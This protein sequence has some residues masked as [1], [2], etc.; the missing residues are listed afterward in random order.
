MTKMCAFTVTNVIQNSN[1]HLT[2]NIFVQINVDIS[3]ISPF[4]IF[5]T[6]ICLIFEYTIL[7]NTHI[8][9]QTTHIDFTYVHMYL[10]V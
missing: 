8:S 6:V 2:H 3:M 4:K 10:Y 5:D 7:L 1:I 9:I